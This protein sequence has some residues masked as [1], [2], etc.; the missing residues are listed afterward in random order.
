MPELW[1]RFDK[2]DDDIMG[3]AY[4]DLI[5]LSG[6][7]FDALFVAHGQKP[8]TE[9]MGVTPQEHRMMCACMPSDLRA[10]WTPKDSPWTRPEIGLAMC[11]NLRRAMAERPEDFSEWPDM[12]AHIIEIIEPFE[13]VLARAKDRDARFQTFSSI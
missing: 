7:P 2:D 13:V 12:I 5:M 10:P 6:T 4:V 8:L 3:D 1:V 9:L 11:R